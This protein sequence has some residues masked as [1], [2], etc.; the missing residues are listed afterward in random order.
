MATIASVTA[1]IP[2]HGCLSDGAG[3]TEA[4]ASAN[5]MKRLGNLGIARRER[6]ILI[7]NA[8][9]R[10]D[11]FYTWPNYNYKFHD[12]DLSE[13]N[14]IKVWLEMIGHNSYPSGSIIYVELPEDVAKVIHEDYDG[15][16]G[17]QPVTWRHIKCDGAI[18]L[19]IGH[20][21]NPKLA[22]DNMRSNATQAELDLFMTSPAPSSCGKFNR[23]LNKMVWEDNGNYLLNGDISVAVKNALRKG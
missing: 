4:E 9:A 3:V 5:L 12:I 22:V 16:C 19:T 11:K 6:T 7:S 20:G 18:V 8:T 14:K 10:S 21:R 1:N 23:K 2:S 13:K 17:Y 15:G